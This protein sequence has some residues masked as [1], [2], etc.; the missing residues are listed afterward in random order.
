MMLVGVMVVVVG[1]ELCA[2]VVCPIRLVLAC[3]T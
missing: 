2:E 1:G 3:D